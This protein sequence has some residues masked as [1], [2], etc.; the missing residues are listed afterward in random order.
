MTVLFPA[1]QL[2]DSGKETQCYNPQSC[3]EKVEE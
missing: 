3:V 2:Q 1:A